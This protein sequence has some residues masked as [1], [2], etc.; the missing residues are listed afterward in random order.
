MYFWTLNWYEQI[1]YRCVHLVFF[2][3]MLFFRHHNFIYSVAKVIFISPKENEE[4][5]E[6]GW[7]GGQLKSPC[8][9]GDKSG[10]LLNMLYGS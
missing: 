5:N 4:N 9:K 3:D 6:V 2:S 7:N 1:R 8:S 10:I